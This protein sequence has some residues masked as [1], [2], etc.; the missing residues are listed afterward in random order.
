MITLEFDV[1]VTRTHNG[2]AI[3]QQLMDSSEYQY[4][5][6][7][8]SLTNNGLT[9]SGD[10]LVTVDVQDYSTAINLVAD[11]LDTKSTLITPED[12]ETYTR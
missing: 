10:Q 12:M 3:L 8:Q 4:S 9:P 7:V 11:Y 2:I 5:N 6:K 1:T